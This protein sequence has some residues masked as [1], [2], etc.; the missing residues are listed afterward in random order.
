M[1]PPYPLRPSS[2]PVSVPTSE[3]VWQPLTACL[4][5]V[6]AMPSFRHV[7]RC[8]SSEMMECS[9]V[10]TGHFCHSHGGYFM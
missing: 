5:G 2:S 10:I 9:A 6:A 4:R 7:I 8:P 3:L 1:P